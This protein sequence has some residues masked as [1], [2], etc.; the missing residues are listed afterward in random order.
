MKTSIQTV[1]GGTRLAFDT[2][3]GITNTVERMHETVA[4]SPLPWSSQPERP[5]RAH[6]LIAAAVY[7]AMADFKNAYPPPE[8]ST[9]L[10][11]ITA[12]TS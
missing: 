5:T 12:E 10:A 4:R 3:E 9:V 6:G 11:A 1:Q 7:A 8:L 2:V